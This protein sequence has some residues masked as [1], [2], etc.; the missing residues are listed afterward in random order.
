LSDL[1]HP[2]AATCSGYGRDIFDLY[3]LKKQEKQQRTQ[4]LT[5]DLVFTKL[6]P[7]GGV[8]VL[9]TKSSGEVQGVG[10][11]LIGAAKDIVAKAEDLEV[12]ETVEDQ[13]EDDT[14]QPTK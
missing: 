4:P 13:A 2:R 10:A 3:Q 14:S 11:E 7:T 9:K 6:D 8:Q 5:H 12:Q 1:H